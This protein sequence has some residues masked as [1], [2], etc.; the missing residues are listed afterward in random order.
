MPR[1]RG[2]T[3][4]KHMMHVARVHEIRGGAITQSQWGP[5]FNAWN[6]SRSQPLDNVTYT[7]PAP[8]VLSGGAITQSQWGPKFNAWNVSRSQPLDNV[9]YTYPAPDVLSG[10]MMPVHFPPLHHVGVL[11]V[12]GLL[13]PLPPAGLALGVVP[14]QPTTIQNMYGAITR[15]LE[16]RANNPQYVND[17]QGLYLG[18]T[19]TLQARMD[20]NSHLKTGN[21]FWN[22]LNVLSLANDVNETHIVNSMLK[23]MYDVLSLSNKSTTPGRRFRGGM[24]PAQY[25]KWKDSLSNVPPPPEHPLITGMREGYHPYAPEWK[26]DRDAR[27]TRMENE[28]NIKEFVHH[29]NL[30]RR[31]K[32]I[33]R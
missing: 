31:A 16:D 22:Q 15:L 23:Y 27:E 20:H 25:K 18:A 9:T 5:K 11:P 33:P 4:H 29:A 12:P 10:G 21:N 6:V 7:Y 13:G 19:N 30:M 14:I 17:I 2:N 24:T 32:H 28:P 26:P 1:T 8:D 3:E